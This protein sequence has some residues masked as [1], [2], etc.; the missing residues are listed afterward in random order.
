MQLTF[1]CERKCVVIRRP[2]LEVQ[3]EFGES[4]NVFKFLDYFL[5]S[6][7]SAQKWKLRTGITEVE[8]REAE[9]LSVV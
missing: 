6:T 3:E 5:Y 8:Q 2:N 9:P 1:Q 7:L 4:R